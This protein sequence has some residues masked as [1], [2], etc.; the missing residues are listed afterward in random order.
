MPYSAAP[1]VY[2]SYE[3][4]VIYDTFLSI[5]IVFK[6]MYTLYIVDKIYDFLFYSILLVE[7][8][9]KSIPPSL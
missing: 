3:I 1:L 6:M 7:Y 8:P 9:D 5:T 2:R 4:S